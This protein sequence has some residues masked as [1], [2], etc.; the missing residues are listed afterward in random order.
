V[1]RPR[2]ET[3]RPSRK[4]PVSIKK[5]KQGDACWSTRKTIL[6]WDLDTV[7]GTL[8]LPTH[9]IERLYALLDAYPPTR[10]RV[11]LTEW[12]QLLGELQSM[13]TALP[14]ARGLFSTLQDALGKGDKHQVK[15]SC[16]VFDSLADFRTIADTLHERPTRFRELIPVGTPMATGACDACQRGMGGVWFVPGLAPIVWRSE[17]SLAI[18][19]ALVT[20]NN[21]SGAISISDLELAGTIAHKQVL[22]QAVPDVAERPIWLAGDNRA[23]LSWATKGSAT[24]TSARA[25]LLRHNA[26]H[27]RRHRYVPLHDHIAGKANVMAD[28]AS[29]R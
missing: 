23:S 6:G 2:D 7:A 16:R 8:S 20:S 14:G 21:R 29:R 25:Y 27:Q 22:I 18:Q 19:R 17:F 3:D 28:D 12:Y 1:L 13:T 4:D 26:L 15:L 11:P 24:S 5:L 10:K 9:R